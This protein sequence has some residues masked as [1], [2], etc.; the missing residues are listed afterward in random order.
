MR[1]TKP[2]SILTPIILAITASATPPAESTTDIS[3]EAPST[4]E[5]WEA[6]R[7]TTAEWNPRRFEVRTTT[8][9]RDAEGQAMGDPLHGRICMSTAGGHPK[10]A[11]ERWGGNGSYARA[12]FDGRMVTWF[13]P[14]TREFERSRPVVATEGDP[15]A[16]LWSWL[17]SP[18]TAARFGPATSQLLE[19]LYF[20]G[21]ADFNATEGPVPIDLGPTEAVMF[22]GVPATWNQPTSAPDAVH[23]ALSGDVFGYPLAVA[24]RLPDGRTLELEYHDWAIES[25]DFTVG[26]FDHPDPTRFASRPPA[27]WTEV[28]SLRIPGIRAMDDADGGEH[29]PGRFAAPTMVDGNRAAS[30]DV[31]E[32]DGPIAVLFHD[33]LDHDS[34]GRLESATAGFELEI[35][36]VQV[37][38]EPGSRTHWMETESLDRVWAFKHLPALIIVDDDGTIL[39]ARSPWHGPTTPRQPAPVASVIETSD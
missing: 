1:A 13:V 22:T 5:S 37:G 12:V 27:A 32:G 16:G 21:F 11:V 10:L 23:V 38:G 14:S 24:T 9:M 18:R 6:A 26:S 30:F 36:G 15:D 31:F 39:E 7:P 33:G 20:D 2:L 19:A 29:Y 28:M 17:R 25:P 35:R 34:M 3:V 4:Q 8:V